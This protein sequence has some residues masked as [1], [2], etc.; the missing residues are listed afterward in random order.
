MNPG[1]TIL[2]ILF[3]T[4]TFADIHNLYVTVHK[5][6]SKDIDIV[7]SLSNLVTC[8]NT[9]SCDTSKS[10]AIVNLSTVV[11]NGVVQSHE[12]YLQITRDLFPLNLTLHVKS[13]LHTVIRES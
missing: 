3:W 12:R 7:H 9:R 1:G 2:K 10:D 6:Q 11:K 5:L 4:A 8:Q 13:E